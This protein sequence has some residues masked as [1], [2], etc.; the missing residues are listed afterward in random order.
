MDSVFKDRFYNG[1]IIQKREERLI[2]DAKWMKLYGISVLTGIDFTMSLF[3]NFLSYNDTK[4]LLAPTN[5]S[6]Y[7]KESI[8]FSYT[9]FNATSLKYL[10]VYVTTDEFKALTY[11][12]SIEQ[13]AQFKKELLFDAKTALEKFLKETG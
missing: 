11:R 8:Q 13:Q 7:S 1:L 5:L 3:V 10:Y 4:N 2:L 6:D 12:I 9:L